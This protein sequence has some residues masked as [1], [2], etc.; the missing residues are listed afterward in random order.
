[1]PITRY[2][3]TLSP[4][5]VLLLILLLPGRSLAQGDDICFECHNDPEMTG[6]AGDTIYVDSERY[7]ESIHAQAGLECVSCH[8]DLEGFEDWPHAERLERVDCSMCHDG[9]FD[10]WDSG[11]HGQP[12]REKGDLD[13][14]GCADCHGKHYILPVE[15]L[16]SRVY[17]TNQ[18]ETCLAC[19]GDPKLAGKHE[20]MGSSDIARS[21]IESVH[22]QAL[23]KSGLTVSATCTSCHGAHKVLKLNEM[24]PEIP[25]TCGKCHAPIYQDYVHGVHGEAF[26]SGNLDVPICTDCHGEHNIRSAEDPGSDVSPSHVSQNCAGC[27]EDISITT[28]YGLP[29][30][31]L[32]SYN[33]TYHGIAL[34]LGDVRVA[35][36]ASCHGYHNIRPSADPESM[37][38]PARLAETCGTCHPN[39]GENFAEGKIHVQGNPEDNIGAWL[40]KRVY[41]IFIAG[42]IGGFVA[43]IVVDLLAH[44][45]RRR[46]EQKNSND[47]EES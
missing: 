5:A 32:D 19:H 36:C 8:L 12:A 44:R 2:I 6:S 41:V 20:G 43:Y 18:P 28:K 13:A 26:Q 27:H 30:G 25:E 34:N 21:F 3:K 17:P 40:V 14:A 33:N 29:L 38:H 45:R 24:L 22:G 7:T 35:N 42:L 47:P 31:R 39:A 23:K 10:M 9:V 15:D 37:T 1:M 4:V 11:V 46:A 16:G